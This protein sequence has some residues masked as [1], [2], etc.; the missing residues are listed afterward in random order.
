MFK[1]IIF[2]F[3]GTMVDS[4]DVLLSVFNELSSKYK[5]N[6]INREEIE[7]LRNMSVIE[8]SRYVNF[9][10]RKIP[11][12]VADFNRL[13]NNNLKK[14]KFF[15]GVKEVLDELRASGYQLSIISSNSEKN[16]REFLKNNGIDYIDEVI[17]ATHFFGKDKTIK[18]YLKSNK[19]EKPQV[20]YVGDEKRDVVACKK[21]GVKVIWVEWG[22]DSRENVMNKGPDYIA[23][24]PENII[25]IVKGA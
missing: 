2:D 12:I 11:T 3:D 17:S 15:D 9:P 6:P 25:D 14:V 18:K 5:F 23:N 22:Y 21:I 1:H 19:L 7:L 10:L 13:Y 4:T 8:R 20:I 24:T 16:I